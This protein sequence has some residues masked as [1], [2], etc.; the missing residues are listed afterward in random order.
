MWGMG[1]DNNESHPMD[2]NGYCAYN[3]RPYDFSIGNVCVNLD[4]DMKKLLKGEIDPAVAPKITD[5]AVRLNWDR[6]AG[7]SP[8]PVEAVTVTTTPLPCEASDPCAYHMM[9][10]S[11]KSAK[12]YYRG[13]EAM[14]RQ[15]IRIAGTLR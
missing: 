11:I 4:E 10:Q 3:C 7:I 9:D 15:N 1:L 12:A 14:A 2:Y 5:P 8:P 6:A 13:A